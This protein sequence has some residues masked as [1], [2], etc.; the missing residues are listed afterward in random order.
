MNTALIIIDIQNDYFKDGRMELVNPDAAADNA[1]QILEWFRKNNKENIFHVQHIA[2]DPS[3]G[4]FLPDT[5]GAEINEFVQPLDNE[6]LITKNFPNSFLNTDL[7]S[8]LKERDIEK[9]YVVGMMTHMCIDATVRAAVDLGYDTTLIEDA[10]AT[11]S[12]S[13]GDE[14]VD[15]Q[16]VH[17]SFVGAL[18][19][20]YAEIITAG[21]FLKQN[22]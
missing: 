5:E 4:F 6:Y 3:L 19:G 20:M 8:K 7:E 21:G 16:Q 17:H 13:H 10:C 18:D 11:R 9:V 14:T 12:L 1:A 15:A 22:K 2:A